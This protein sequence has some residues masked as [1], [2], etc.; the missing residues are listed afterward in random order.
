MLGNK[1]T[2][3]ACYVC[4]VKHPISTGT[5]ANEYHK[6]HYSTLFIGLLTADVTISQGHLGVKRVEF[7]VVHITCSGS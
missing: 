5:T 3:S 1:H 2:F 7:S 4:E 6:Q